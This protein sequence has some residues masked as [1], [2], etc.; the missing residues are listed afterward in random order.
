MDP[1]EIQDVHT[2]SA[3]FS[4]QISAMCYLEES[5]KDTHYSRQ[6]IRVPLHHTL[7]SAS[8]VPERDET[9]PRSRPL[10]DPDAIVR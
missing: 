4:Y 7:G 2:S 10:C 8:A 1:D 9:I 3:A 6:E 5:D